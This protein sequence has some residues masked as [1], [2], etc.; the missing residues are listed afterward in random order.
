M[1]PRIIDGVT[2]RQPLCA[3]IAAAKLR[4]EKSRAC[5]VWRAAGPLL[6]RDGAKACMSKSNAFKKTIL[7]KAV[8][9]PHLYLKWRSNKSSHLLPVEVSYGEKPVPIFKAEL[10]RK[11]KS[12]NVG[13]KD[14]SDRKPLLDQIKTERWLIM[15][16]K[17]TIRRW[18]TKDSYHEAGITMIDTWYSRCDVDM[19][20]C[21][22]PASGV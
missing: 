10:Q 12:R 20:F 6:P 11:L 8:K 2:A 21:L 9:L 1:S 4:G 18:R 14:I 16:W 22:E 15:W 19:K 17:S 7:R 3:G 13:R 5:A